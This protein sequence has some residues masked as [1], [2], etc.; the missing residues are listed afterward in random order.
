M[1]VRFRRTGAR[2][3]AVVVTVVGEPPRAMDPAPG[4]D[5]DIPHDLVHYVVEAELGLTSGVYGRAARGAGTFITTAE[6]DVRPRDRARRQRRQQRRERSLGAQD[7]RRAADMAR[8]EQLAA[9]CD[10]AWRR[11]HGQ[12]PDAARSAPV[13]RRDDAADVERVVSRL[14]AIA[15]LWRALPVG[16]E[17][18]FEWPNVMPAQGDATLY[19]RR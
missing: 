12:Q 3:Y 1:N 16:G 2:R 15:P 4:Y 13:P 17:L 9:R 19:P 8:S 11:K 6:H 18:V 7:A 5:D 10:V 14:D